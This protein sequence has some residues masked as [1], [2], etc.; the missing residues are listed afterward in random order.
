MLIPVSNCRIAL[1]QALEFANRIGKLDELT[2]YLFRLGH[3]YHN[4]G[5]E[6]ICV[7]TKDFAPYSFEFACYDIDGVFLKYYEYKGIQ[8]AMVIH[9]DGSK[10]WMS[11]GLIYHG[12]HDNGGDGSF[13]TL[14]VNISSIDGW[15]IHT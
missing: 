8:E 2:R 15:S 5:K 4:Q 10:P 6:Y 11:G 3:G 7:L 14:S 1:Q 12:A 9:R 13:P